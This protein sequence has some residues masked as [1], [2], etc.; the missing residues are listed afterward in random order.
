MVDEVV[1]VLVAAR[2][3]ARRMWEAAGGR[4]GVRGDARVIREIGRG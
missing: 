4:R 3:E 1:G 2:E